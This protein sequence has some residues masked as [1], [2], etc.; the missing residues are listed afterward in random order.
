MAA[1][2]NPGKP[3]DDY[4]ARHTIDAVLLYSGGL[5]SYVARFLFHPR[6]MLFFDIGTD[7]SAQELIRIERERIGILEIIDLAAL[8]NFQGENM[9]LPH[10][11]SI[12]ALIASNYGSNIM[13]GAGLA[14]HRDADFVWGAMIEAQLNYFDDPAYGLKYHQPFHILMPFKN[15][16]K[17]QI[18]F[19]YL[20][21]GGEPRKFAEISR[22]CE[23]ATERECGVCS[24]CLRKGVAMVNNGLFLPDYIEMV[25]EQNP[26][27][28]CSPELIKKELT[29]PTDGEDLKSA[30]NTLGLSYKY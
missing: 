30:L 7:G 12:F 14:A 21:H 10:R 23:A 29:R 18:L 25:F 16:T 20:K 15:M 9:T 1:K 2:I 26:F 4:S 19:E 3:Q 5:E 11:N 6:K 27:M 17:S 22:S 13:I 8:G 28:A 24:K